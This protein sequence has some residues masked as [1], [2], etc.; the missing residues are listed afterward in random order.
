MTGTGTLGSGPSGPPGNRFRAMFSEEKLQRWIRV[1]DRDT[2]QMSTGIT[3]KLSDFH[4]GSL[5]PWEPERAGGPRSGLS[6]E[7]NKKL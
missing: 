7:C 3:V 5:I 1:K 2:P 4:E 6:R